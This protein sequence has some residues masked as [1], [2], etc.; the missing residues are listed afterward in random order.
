LSGTHDA[1]RGVGLS[2]AVPACRRT[3]FGQPGVLS[4]N[5]AA[6]LIAWLK[7]KLLRVFFFFLFFSFSLFLFFSFFFS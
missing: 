1:L 4:V 6:L 3:V 5:R 2:D 7:E